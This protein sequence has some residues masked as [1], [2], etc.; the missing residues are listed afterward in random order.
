[1]LPASCCW[2]SCRLSGKRG[3]LL[4]SPCSPADTSH[5][6]FCPACCCCCRRLW[7][8]A[9]GEADLRHP[10]SSTLAVVAL[11]P[12]AQQQSVP[13]AAVAAGPGSATA[14]AVALDW[15]REL[16]VFSPDGCQLIANTRGH[17]KVGSSAAGEDRKCA[18]SNVLSTSSKYGRLSSCRMP[19]G[20]LYTASLYGIMYCS[21][22]HLWC[23]IQPVEM[24][25]F[26][27]EKAGSR[28][29]AF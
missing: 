4:A 12:R 14:G 8:D 10:I 22:L 16:A 5:L 13:A 9:R 18:D 27:Q 2:W 23:T 15:D 6:L 21:A 29:N 7:F 17:F 28:R 25:Q 11:Q 24:L 26:V 19:K 20:P 3:S 1:V